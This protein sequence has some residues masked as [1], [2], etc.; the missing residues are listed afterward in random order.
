LLEAITD[1][2]IWILKREIWIAFAFLGI[3]ITYFSI[4]LAGVWFMVSQLNDQ[5]LGRL[6]EAIAHLPK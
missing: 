5:L 6:N 2:K 4:T 1:L 3:Q